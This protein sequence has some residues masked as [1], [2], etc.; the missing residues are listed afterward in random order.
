MIKK[1]SETVK[2]IF[3]TQQ[4]TILPLFILTLSLF[5]FN[6]VLHLDW[7]F[8]VFGIIF[9]SFIFPKFIKQ[10]WEK[11]FLKSK[12]FEVYLNLMF[13]LESLFVSSVSFQF[14]TGF[15]L[16]IIFDVFYRSENF[17]IAWLAL[18]IFFLC[19]LYFRL[20]TQIFS[21]NELAYDFSND[22]P[23][24][25]LENHFLKSLGVKINLHSIKLTRQFESFR[26]FGVPKRK[27]FSRM[28]SYG[29]T[30]VASVFGGSMIGYVGY[31][32][33]T[34]AAERNQSA[35]RAVDNMNQT[36]IELNNQYEL[37]KKFLTI[38]QKSQAEDL[39]RETQYL[40]RDAHLFA[41]K[42]DLMLIRIFN[43]PILTDPTFTKLHVKAT[44]KLA[45]LENQLPILKPVN[46]E[47]VIDFI[48][49]IIFI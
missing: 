18:F 24:N 42:R 25:T 23:I 27:M 47:L 17:L 33:D 35:F 16:I 46:F 7:Y 12:I 31:I 49:Q 6:K 39:L 45:L 44:N 9:F 29:S 19:I 1:F 48:S 32:L 13:F 3:T 8:T 15:Y 21:I 34:N 22:I 5:I 38:E 30:K 36:F 4:L 14:M 43:G 28:V 20:R 2:K 40:I 11:L 26:L 41:Y 10:E 37:K